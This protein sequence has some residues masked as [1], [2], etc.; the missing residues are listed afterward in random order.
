MVAV[1]ENDIEARA[2]NT[3]DPDSQGPQKE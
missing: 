2:S 1:Q 3:E